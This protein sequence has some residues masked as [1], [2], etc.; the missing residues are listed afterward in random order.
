SARKVSGSLVARF[1]L[2]RRRSKRSSSSMQVAAPATWMP[3]TRLRA[4]AIRA[5][6]GCLRLLIVVDPLFSSM[7]R[8]PC[9]FGADNRRRNVAGTRANATDVGEFAGF[10]AGLYSPPKYGSEA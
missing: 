6:P 10:K 2:C 9:N 3:R 7:I 5:G 4:P 8:H 1:E